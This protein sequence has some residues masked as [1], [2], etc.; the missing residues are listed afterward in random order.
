MKS[1]TFVKPKASNI[2]TIKKTYAQLVVNKRKYYGITQEKLAK[3]VGL[4]RKTINRIENGHFSPSLDT[5]I[6]LAYVLKLKP[7]EFFPSIK[8]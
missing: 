6:R 2:K 4:D 7:V 8:A 1:Y 3:L 5:M